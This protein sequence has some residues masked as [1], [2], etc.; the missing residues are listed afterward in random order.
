MTK[1]LTLTWTW[2]WVC[3]ECETVNAHTGRCSKC[4]AF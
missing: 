4:G 1:T 3:F 2:T